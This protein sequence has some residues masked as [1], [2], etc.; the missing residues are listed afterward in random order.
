V[1]EAKEWDASL[2]HASFTDADFQTS[3]AAEPLAFCFNCHAPEA[4]HRDDARGV[5]VGVGCNSCHSVAAGHGT[6]NTVATTTDCASCHEFSFPNKPNKPAAALMQSTISEHR[7]S[8][9]A[10][11]ACATCHMPYKPSGH[12]DHR[13]DVTRNEE[14]LRRALQLRAKRTPSG[15]EIVLTTNN[16]GHAMP[17]GDLFRRLRVSVHAQAKDGTLIDERELAM[18][19]TTNSL[20]GERRLSFEGAALVHASSIDV[21]VYYERVAQTFTNGDRVFASLRIAEQKL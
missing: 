2:H 16:V 13:F 8:A 10:S 5:K 1:D 7:A 19:R 18:D 11:V 21:D 12:R 9:F 14:L 4:K 15:L 6:T 17:T 3:F 20:R